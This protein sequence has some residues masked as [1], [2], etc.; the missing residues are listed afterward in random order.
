[1]SGKRSLFTAVGLGVALLVLA[2]GMLFW[3][4]APR[5]SGGTQTLVAT[6]E[7]ALDLVLIDIADRD[8]AA[9]YH[10]NEPGVYVLAVNEQSAAYTAG[11]RSGDRIVSM[12]GVL[13]STSGEFST[14]R[15]ALEPPWKMVLELAR[16][17]GAQRL[18]VTMNDG[19][20]RAI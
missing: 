11:V 17:P 12:N 4:A 5:D 3:R 1:M 9:V 15:A 8:A 20:N 16:G 2:A 13:V 18:T 14:L 6:D 7:N 10:V 19:E